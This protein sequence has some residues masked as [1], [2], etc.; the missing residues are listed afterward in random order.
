VLRNTWLSQVQVASFAKPDK[1]NPGNTDLI[2]DRFMQEQKK[3]F[4]EKL[5]TKEQDYMKVDRLALL[6]Q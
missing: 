3:L 2:D 4:E 6:A 1:F 5:S